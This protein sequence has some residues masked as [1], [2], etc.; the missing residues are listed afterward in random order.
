MGDRVVQYETTTVIKCMRLVNV[1]NGVALMIAG[2]VV[3]AG[4][5]TCTA[6]CGPATAILSFYTFLFG[7]ML[8]LFEA[9]VGVSYETFFRKYFGFM[10]GYWGRFL[11]VLFLASMCISIINTNF[12]FWW[13]QVLVGLITLI[14]AL[15]NCFVIRKH[16]GFQTGEAQALSE[17]DR[18]ESMAAAAARQQERQQQQQHYAAQPPIGLDP[19]APARGS[20]RSNGNAAYGGNNSGGGGDNPFAVTVV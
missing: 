1:I 5:G 20:G 18:M 13:V 16:P 9:R 12:D 14:N 3:L 6:G 2:V 11:F 7:L 8:F 17:Q 4:L 19:F 10:F 15:F